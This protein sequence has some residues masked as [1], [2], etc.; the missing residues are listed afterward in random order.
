MFNSRNELYRN[1][2]GAVK[3]DEN[4]HLRIKLSRSL[5]C[6]NARLVVHAESGETSVSDLFWCGM[7]GDKEE[8]WECDF[9]PEKPGLYF[10]YF[11]LRTIHGLRKLSKGYGGEGTFDSNDVW[12][13]TAYSKDFETPSWLEGGIIYQIFPDRF[14]SSNTPK[15]NT[16]SYRRNHDD[17]YEDPYWAPDEH[18][19]I[20][21]DDF[22]GGD[23][24][25]VEEKLPYLKELGVTCIYFNPIF[26]SYSH[27]GYDTADYSLVDP[28]LGTEEDLSH[29]CKTAK[30]KYGIHIIIDGVFSHTGSDSIYFNKY[31]HFDSVG[32][33]NSQDSEYYSWYNF[34]EWPQKYESWWGFDT[35]PNVNE[36]DPAYNEFIN[37]ENGIARK[38]LKSGISGWRLDVADELPD[39]FLDNFNKAVKSYDKEALI[40]GEVW[41]DASTKTAYG[42]R[43]RYLL[44]GQ[45][46][47]V[48]NYP[49]RNSIFGFL[50]GGSADYFMESVSQILENYPP[51]TIK[52][53]MNHIGTHDTER[54]ITVLAGDP[55][56]D[57]D[58]KWQSEMR[59]SEKQF[60]LGIKRMKLASL[61]QYTLPG[62][63]C[64][65]YGDEAG[66]EGYKDPFSR[67]TYP[68][69]KENTELLSWYKNLGQIRA[70][71][72]MLANA[73]F[74][75][76]YSNGDV[77]M[78]ERFIK[79]D[80]S[81]EVM[82]TIVNRGKK[83]QLIPKDLIDD[84]AQLILGFDCRGE[85]C[86]LEPFGYA[87]YKYTR[88]IEVP[89]KVSCEATEKPL[90]TDIAEDIE[91]FVDPKFFD[92]FKWHI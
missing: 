5:S 21:N 62:V 44:G 56:H 49:F 74:R 6:S 14:H 32:A 40:L 52:I 82:L 36:T 34:I 37:G 86:E 31:N 27:H 88:E 9:T 20:G 24:K 92:K 78:Y 38:W 80:N 83:I 29:L 71:Q 28:Q 12:Q 65:Y 19:I 60:E 8:W 47:S 57:G 76:I 90:E 75:P 15:A 67:R 77:I 48:M 53:L 51:Q 84:N 41:E 55:I 17:W 61:I 91:E 70:S 11:E 16:P 39:V 58:R 45:L 10:Y 73:K 63:P 89:V 1:P 50:L 68:W 7:E 64:I 87:V 33:Y 59:L 42:I 23:F 2:V 79:S 13:I 4:I 25:G 35:L 18:G 85:E 43:R 54:A 81:E 3:E 72:K 46:D 22:F 30:E 26:L 69:N 66:V